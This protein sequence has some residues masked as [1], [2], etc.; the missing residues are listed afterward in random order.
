MTFVFLLRSI[1]KDWPTG[2]ILRLGFSSVSSLPKKLKKLVKT[3]Q[4]QCMRRFPLHQHSGQNEKMTA[5]QLWVGR[6]QIL[7]YLDPLDRGKFNT[8]A[9]I[10][11]FCQIQEKKNSWTVVSTLERFF[12]LQN[13]SEQFWTLFLRFLNGLWTFFPLVQSVPNGINHSSVQNRSFLGLAL[14]IPVLG[15]SR[16]Q[17]CLLKARF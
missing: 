15:S 12:S 6:M 3:P 8:K 16:Y 10:D 5:M 13:A 2:V 14:K 4:S 11:K 9:K 1:S 7:W 17:L